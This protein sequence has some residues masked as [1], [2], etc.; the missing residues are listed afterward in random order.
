M[1]IVKTLFKYFI[2]CLFVFCIGKTSINILNI[3]NASIAYADTTNED[4][5]SEC[6]NNDNCPSERPV[7][8][9]EHT[10]ITCPEGTIYDTSDKTCVGCLEHYDCEMDNAFCDKKHKVCK[11]CPA[12]KIFDG[13]KCVE[14]TPANSSKCEPGQICNN[15]NKCEDT[16]VCSKDLGVITVVKNQKIIT[17]QPDGCETDTMKYYECAESRKEPRVENAIKCEFGCK[18]D[19]KGCR[20]HEC[21]KDD[22]LNCSGNN[23]YCD[24][25]QFKCVECVTNDNC[26]KDAPICNEDK[27]CESCD[28]GQIYDKVN[29]ICVGCITN[30]DCPEESPICNDKKECEACP[31]DFY[32]NYKNKTCVECLTSVNC[33]VDKPICTQENRCEDCKKGTYYDAESNTCVEC[34]SNDNCKGTRPICNNKKCEACPKDKPAFDGLQCVECTERNQ[35][36][37]AFGQ[38]CVDNVCVGGNGCEKTNGVVTLRENYVE[39]TFKDY[40]ENGIRTIYTCSTDTLSVI[41][42]ITNCEFG[43]DK[44]KISCKEAECSKKDTNK[45]VGLKPYCDFETNECIQC[46]TDENCKMFDKKYCDK[47]EHTCYECAKDDDCKKDASANVK[48]DIKCDLETR[49]CKNNNKPIRPF[50]NCVQNNFDGTFTAY[51]GYENDNNTNISI[52]ACQKVGFKENT[53]NNLKEGFCK[54]PSEFLT[55]THDGVFSIIFNSDEEVVWTLQNS[56]L[57]KN[58]AVA[59]ASS[60]KCIPITPTLQCIDKMENGNFRAHFG[61]IN[62]NNFNISIPIGQ[63]NNV[64]LIGEV[65]KEETQPTQFLPGNINSAFY[66]DFIDKVS[67]NLVH[68]KANAN[69]QSKICME[70]NC[71]EAIL[72]DKKEQIKAN[73]FEKMLSTQSRLLLIEKKNTSRYN[74]LIKRRLNRADKMSNTIK[75]LIDSL[76]S[77]MFNCL[78]ADYCP[79]DDNELLISTIKQKFLKLHKQVARTINQ[80]SIYK[81]NKRALL[82]K[83]KAIKNQKLKLLSSIPRFANNCGES[84]D[85]DEFKIY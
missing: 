74:R 50:L 41:N 18:K 25:S 53:I 59:N 29:Q 60:M 44:D 27:K 5:H 62:K 52:K 15:K 65:L 13:E 39:T 11:L 4:S 42:E 20:E 8:S 61:Y 17:K 16:Y 36:K 2:I 70:T 40:C 21:D 10:C 83:S 30:D 81:K 78:D 69:S 73:E 72:T 34:L 33:P 22:T 28:N 45:C 66:V 77:I 46:L 80:R 35:D 85:G 3:N 38:T 51:F 82:R 31:Q 55:G 23:P 75:K 76:P 71:T 14:C 26:P 79:L 48:D 67:W 9:K 58:S 56:K 12:H 49:T 63:F 43:C 47:K 7:C 19:K 64:T 57:N 84:H 37:C 24:L 6:I 32:Y 1:K 54:Q 68:Q